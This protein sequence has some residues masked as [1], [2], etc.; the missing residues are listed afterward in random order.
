MAALAT[1]GGTSVELDDQS[2]K[3]MLDRVAL[4]TSPESFTEFLEE[5][6]Q[7]L[8]LSA[9][10]SRFSQEGDTASGLW[11]QLAPRT[12]RERARLGY[13]PEHPINYR[14]G[15][16]ERHVL[17]DG[18]VQASVDEVSWTWPPTAGDPLTAEKFATAQGG[19]RK[20]A[21]PRPVV[22]YQQSD[23]ADILLRLEVRL[24][25]VLSI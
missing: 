17:Q 3:E 18:Q 6:V 16:L 15:D 23:L 13:G 20:G 22:A 2:V 4:A 25:S 10:V 11:K 21:P 19:N 24:E 1:R 9:A 8:F 5:D 7:P 14:T 12:Q